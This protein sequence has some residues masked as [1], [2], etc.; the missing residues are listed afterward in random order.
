MPHLFYLS[1]SAG[2]FCC[3]FDLREYCRGRLARISPSFTIN[4]IGVSDLV[5]GH[6][7]AR[8]HGSLTQL[9]SLLSSVLPICF[10]RRLSSPSNQGNYLLGWGPFIFHCCSLLLGYESHLFPSPFSNLSASA[11]KYYDSVNP[12]RRFTSRLSRTY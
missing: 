5:T 11:A 12:L 9:S 4:C 3:L 10:S 7:R 8:R 1:S 6:H 2:I